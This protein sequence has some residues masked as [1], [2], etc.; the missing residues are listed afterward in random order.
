MIYCA[1]VFHISRV[2]V[3]HG[4]RKAAKQDILVP[5]IAVKK[6]NC[7]LIQY[8]ISGRMQLSKKNASFA[9]IVVLIWI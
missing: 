3:M 4:S 5:M 1:A 8:T 7:L 6:E 9:V 2:K